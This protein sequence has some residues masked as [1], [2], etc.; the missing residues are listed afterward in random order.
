M[1][2]ECWCKQMVKSQ[3]DLTF[4]ND[5]LNNFISF[6]NSTIDI[7]LDSLALIFI[8]IDRRSPILADFY[9]GRKTGC[10]SAKIGETCCPIYWC[11]EK[12]AD[13]LQR[14]TTPRFRIFV[15]N[16]KMKLSALAF[17]AVFAAPERDLFGQERDT[18]CT[19]KGGNCQEQCCYF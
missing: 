19:A 10:I 9:H 7:S 18:R 3:G 16:F 13:D 12:I 11:F 14:K 17:S 4:S 5:K 15:T 8:L 2:F 6:K 1:T